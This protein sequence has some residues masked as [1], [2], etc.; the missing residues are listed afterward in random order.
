MPRRNVSSRLIALYSSGQTGPAA[1]GMGMQMLHCKGL[2]HAPLA[3]LDLST[4]A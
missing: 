1:Q 3:L 2:L 4:C